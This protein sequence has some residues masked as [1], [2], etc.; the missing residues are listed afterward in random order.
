[1]GLSDFCTECSRHE[2]GLLESTSATFSFIYIDIHAQSQ[3]LKLAVNQALL[4]VLGLFKKTAAFHSV[5]QIPLIALPLLRFPRCRTYP[6]S[7]QRI[8]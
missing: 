3:N 1:M 5:G 4:V 7:E 8:Q 2:S 6:T